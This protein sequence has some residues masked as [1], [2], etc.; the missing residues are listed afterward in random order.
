MLFSVVAIVPTIVIATFSVLFFHF[1]LQ[2]WFSDRVRTALGESLAVAEAYLSEHRQTIIGD[3]LAMANDFNREGPLLLANPPRLQR[4]LEGQARV[5]GLPEA[6]VFDR[7]GRVQLGRA[8]CR[9]SA[10]R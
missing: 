2:G 4:F 10:W 7:A 3:V 6:V 8:S 5:L 1:G 9:G